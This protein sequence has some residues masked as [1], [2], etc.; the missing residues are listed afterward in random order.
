MSESAK[1]ACGDSCGKFW[2]DFACPNP[3]PPLVTVS[4][5]EKRVRLAALVRSL[6]ARSC[7]GCCLHVVLDD[8]NIEDD[9]VAWSRDLAI[10]RSCQE[11]AVIA[12]LLAEFTDAERW[13]IYKS[14][15]R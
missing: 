6:Y 7:V 10:E 15:W 14:G 12:D 3:A 8:G 1:Q 9:D 11:C 2:H 5:T 4:D 13:A